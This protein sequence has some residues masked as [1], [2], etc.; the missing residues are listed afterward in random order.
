MGLLELLLLGLIAAEKINVCY[1]TNWAQYR[2]EPQKFFPEDIDVSLCS[3]IHY[4][5]AFV[6]DDGTG[7]RTFEWN[8]ED[9]YRRVLALKSRK[10][11][12]VFYLL[13]PCS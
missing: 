2:K 11:R 9:M 13:A 5:F 1:Y 7:L 4:A 10:P 3:H 8:D 6:T 12:K